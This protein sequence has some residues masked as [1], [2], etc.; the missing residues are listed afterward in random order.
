MSI[1][2]LKDLLRPV[3][4]LVAAQGPVDLATVRGVI[5]DRHLG[6]TDAGG[7]TFSED[8]R[9]QLAVRVLWALDQLVKA[10]CV[11]AVARGTY[12]V[13]ATGREWL[14][15]PETELA[16]SM[17]AVPAEHATTQTQDRATPVTLRSP[18]PS[19]SWVP[20]FEELATVL[21]DWRHRQPELIAFLES[22]RAKDL[23]I[24]PLSDR[25]AE[26][27]RFLLEEIDPF[28]FVGVVHRGITFEQRVAITREM[29]GFFGV[30]A[31]VPHDF[32]GVPIQNNMLSWFIRFRYLRDAGDADL[33][34]NVFLRSLAPDPWSD[35]LFEQALDAGFSLP[36]VNRKLAMGLFWVRPRQ[37]IALDQHMRRSLGIQLPSGRITGADYRRIVHEQTE[38]GANPMV[39]SLQ[40]WLEAQHQT[41]V[42]D[43]A[44]PH[45][46]AT[47]GPETGVG[48]WLVG[49]FWSGSEGS[50]SQV[51]R[52][53]R[54]GIWENG[55]E[56]RYLDQVR[57]IREGDKIAIKATF[58]QRSDLPFEYGDRTAS[59]MR[60]HATGTVVG[61]AGDGRRVE[62]E[63]DPEVETR[64]W[65]FY[66]HRKTV[67]RLSTDPSHRFIEYTRQLVDFV[68]NGVPQDYD[69]FLERWTKSA[70]GPGQPP[71]DPDDGETVAKPYGIEDLVNGG[72]FLDET[73]LDRI[74]GLI[75]SKK[76]VILQG[77]PGVGK[78]FLVRRLAYALM[79]ERDDD[80]IEIVQF[81]QSYAYED[82]IRGYRPAPKGKR[83][84]L[85]DGVFL[86]F[87]ER[88][89]QDPDRP[90]VFVIDEIN[91]GNLSQIFGELLMLIEADKRSKTYAVP[92]TY[93]HDDEPRFYVPDN[94]HVLG[95]MNVADRSLAMVDYALRR[96][97]AFI[98]LEPQFESPA[99]RRWLEAGSMRPQLID[100]IVNRMTNLNA[101]ITRDPLLGRNYRVGHSF[102]C[103]RGETYA[104]LDRAWYERVVATEVAPLL[105]EY[106]FDDA[107]KA[108]DAINALLAS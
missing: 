80:R 82:F 91:R 58:T 60:I 43:A 78:T 56:D 73:T 36:A 55:Y 59:V 5:A 93:R 7:A 25:D 74:I 42:T 26:G 19:F 30:A 50:E 84:V 65:Y 85:R 104:D 47:L 8:N 9:A 81:H 88:A 23:V 89:Q 96:R 38:G 35:P 66:T 77:P 41:A 46:P 57:S 18:E 102:F 107:G 67:W 95:L 1:P 103:P 13:T 45:Q 94:V 37:F 34:W 6:A 90:Y 106:W 105:R 33:L 15:R 108:D 17:L 53:L 39:L 63:W 31:P 69:W 49:A 12:E 22:L 51:E 64:D 14:D 29:K 10:E 86:S 83:F 101:A 27:K 28:T 2:A 62:V 11:Q 16:E 21:A 52:F 44:D 24:T 61:N 4:D 99:F 48:Y 54:E 40:A 71:E 79:G 72:V 97:F 68:W 87:C 100:L 76:A 98:D 32:E 75:R 3:L 20:F 70:T 92:L